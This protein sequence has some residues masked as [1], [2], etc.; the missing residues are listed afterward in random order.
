MELLQLKYFSHAAKTE[1][2]SHTAQNFHV[3]TS[4]ISA[5]I[6]K[7]E[8]EIGVRLFDRTANRI[9]LNE[10][11]KIF[12]KAVD[13]SEELLKKAKADVLDLAKITPI[14]LR[15]LIMSNRQKI[16]DVISE[17]K[18]RYPETYFTIHHGTSFELSNINEYD[19]IIADRSIN[20]DCFEKKLWIKEDILLAVHKNHRLAQ[21][22]TVTLQELTDE[23]FIFMTKGSNLRDHVDVFLHQQGV[24][25]DAVIE[26]DDPQYVQKYLKMGLGI[27]F[28]PCI[29]WKNQI[30]DDIRLLKLTEPLHRDSYIYINK[31]STDMAKTFSQMLEKA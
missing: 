7:L 6:K 26:C 5:S 19:I 13:A 12:L 3:P 15:L 2:F 20:S 18:L 22:E 31:S 23:K 16:T 27:T 14:E 8:N 28:F 21:R 30:N 1:N 17:F 24:E 25:V 10:C 29:S 9:K 4:C 11:G